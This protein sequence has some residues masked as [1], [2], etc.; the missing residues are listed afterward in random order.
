MIL[1][2][3]SV[4]PP[5]PVVSAFVGNDLAEALSET[6]MVT[7]ISPKPTRPSGFIFKEKKEENK[8]YKHVILDS[9]TYPESRLL[10]RMRESYSFGKHAVK[11]IKKYHSDIQC[12]FIHAWP[13][14]AQYLIIR[15]S[16]KFGIPAISHI[17]DVYPEALIGKLP[18]FKSFFYNLLLPVDKYVLKKSLKVITISPKMKKYL[19]ESRKLE[20]DKVEVVYNWQNEEWFRQFMTSKNTINEN[21]HF[22]FMYLGNLSRTAALDVVINAFNKSS[23]ENSRLII[24][25]NGSE[26]E[27]LMSVVED[28][29]NLNISFQ[30]APMEQVPEI[31]DNADVL[32]LSL[33]KGASLFALPSKL[34]AYMFSGKPIIACVEEDSDTAEAIKEA[35]CGW[36]IEPQNMN[37]LIEIMKKAT[38]MSKQDML[39]I[40][41]NGSEYSWKNY[42][43]K[44]NL[45]KMVN[46]IEKSLLF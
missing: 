23:L 18:F 19:V 13:I 40:G 3:S 21:T 16:K 43:R 14:F 11:Y 38:S 39:R 45:D 46:I 15:A 2:I 27:S 6:N 5:E 25:G 30:N 1:I 37:A 17:V 34:S 41:K 7:V 44:T 24:A 10:G 20:E 26:K 35:G 12:I 4:F 32:V 8:K 33:K 22:T 28:C 36:I 31:Q 42:C 29:N 9:Y